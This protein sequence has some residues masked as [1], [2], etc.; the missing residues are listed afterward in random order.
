MEWLEGKFW[1]EEA[2]LLVNYFDLN[3]SETSSF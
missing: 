3:I 1:E 2:L